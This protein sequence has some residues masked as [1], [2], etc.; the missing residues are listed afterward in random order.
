[1][2]DTFSTD[3]Y[4]LFKNDAVRLTKRTQ[5]RFY[6]TFCTQVLKRHGGCTVVLLIPGSYMGV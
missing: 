4:R 6:I 2:K 1:M 3:N 5:D